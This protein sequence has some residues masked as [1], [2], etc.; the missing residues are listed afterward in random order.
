[1]FGIK[2]GFDV[3]I[4]NPPYINVER[5]APLLKDYLFGNYKTCKGRTDI[6]IAFIEKSLQILKQN[7]INTFIIP[8]AYTNQNYA[9]LSRMNLVRNYG[10]REILDASNYY[11]FENAAV[12]NII[13]R[14]KNEYEKQTKIRIA[15]SPL[16]FTHNKFDERTINTTD[17]LKLKNVRFATNEFEKL[18]S[19]KEKIEKTSL[20]LENICLAAYGIRI[21]HKADKNKPKQFYLS[22]KKIKDY[23]KFVEGKNI[24]R[25]YHKQNG[26]LNYKPQ[27]HYNSMFSELFENEK[28]ITINVVSEKLRFSLDREGLYDSHTVINCV[29][30]DK[31]LRTRHISARKSVR[32]NDCTV[33]KQFSM[34]YLLAVLNS[35]LIN[36]YFLNFQSEGLHFYPD[37]AK[38][39]P[40]FNA[41][42]SKQNK[43][44]NL[45]DKI[46]GAKATGPQ[47][48]I[49]I[50]DR[51][52]DNFV[53]RLYNL[54]WEEVRVIEPGF[55]MSKVEYERIGV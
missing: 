45:V 15:E 55:P 41:D 5:L 46:L 39:L 33:A 30:I 24:E 29:R 26:W 31:L 2:D 6:Y 21:N 14:I 53:Y 8:Y 1:M 47:T 49:S 50:L 25:Y 27:E 51:Q 48:D 9:A 3:V 22:N 28:I 7:G 54:T 18:L 38:K 35:R 40:I 13:I 17:F 20:K 23:K 19:V 16:S 34:K 36:W 11:I 4:G 10:I 42:K 12:K 44:D 52:I 43:F 32:E 37:D